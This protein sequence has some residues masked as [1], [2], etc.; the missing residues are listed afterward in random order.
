MFQKKAESIAKYVGMLRSA[1]STCNYGNHL[2]R[3]LRDQFVVGLLEAEDQEDLMRQDRTLE[4]CIQTAAA[5]EAAHD[6]V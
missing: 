5:T 6:Q 4:Q 3:A 2:Q 1:A